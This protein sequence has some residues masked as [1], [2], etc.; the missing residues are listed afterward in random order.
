[1]QFTEAEAVEVKDW[2]VKKLEHISDADSDVLADY[3][4]ALIRSDAPDEEIKKASLENLE[5]FLRENTAQ[6]V[7][8]IFEKFNPKKP[9]PPTA[10]A[11]V[12]SRQQQVQQQQQFLNPTAAS[13]EGNNV[14]QM[15]QQQPY[16]QQQFPTGP[17]NANNRG[18]GFDNNT[19]R[20]RSF[21]EHA[22]GEEQMISRDTNR[23]FKQPRRG[24]MGM[25]MGMGMG[26][27][28][29][30]MGGGGR[31]QHPAQFP[32]AGQQPGGGA[33]FP[34][35]PPAPPGFPPFDPN[36]PMAAMLA[37]QNMFPQMP[38]MPPMPQVPT[39]GGSGGGSGGQQGQG[40]A[41]SSPPAR[42]A[43]RCKDYDTQGF[44][45]LGSTCPYLH[46][47]EHVVAAEEDG[48]EYDPTNARIIDTKA[49]NGANG[50][51]RSSPFR[52]NGR[53]RGGRGR[54]A[55][56]GGGRGD[57][58][59]SQRR[60]RADFSLAGPNDDKSI[61]TI[62]VEQIPEEKF[63]EESIRGFF[64][65][66]GEIVDVTLQAYKHLALVKYDSY[67]S[68]RKAWASPKVIFDNRFVKV[69]WYKPNANAKEGGGGG[70][71]PSGAGAE[72]RPEEPAFDKE[73]FEKQQADAQRAYEEKVKKRKEAEEAREK[74]EKQKEELF[75]K[76]Q[77]ERAKLMERLGGKDASNG[78]TP[79]REGSQENGNG[80]GATPATAQVDDNASEQTKALRAQLAAL[81][82]E[83]KSLGIDP[84]QQQNGDWSSSSYRG[85][86]RGRGGFRARG[87]F[88]PRG[89]GGGYDPSYRGGA[90]YRGRGGPPRGG[91]AGGR[92][93]VLRL[94][95]RP[96]RVAISG[97]Q[98]DAAR[99]EALR[100]FLVGV[101]GFD[102]IEQNPSRPDSQIVSF[103]DRYMAEQ[104]MYGPS[105]IPEVG[106]VEFSWVAGPAPPTAGSSSGAAGATPGQNGGD[107]GDTMMGGAGAG[108]SDPLAA[109]RKDG[110]GNGNGGGGGH[111]VD[112]DVAEVDDGWGI[113]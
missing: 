94:D 100:Q 41:G 33:G 77:E 96:K 86:G 71:R 50:G 92:G 52:G 65:E 83:A 101:G 24:G 27:G 53:E 75:K 106:K 57:F 26:R 59:S 10:P 6:F 69:Y 88:A 111:E 5:D 85:R 109:M 104:L 42:I 108:E 84:E 45:V 14:P 55:R 28:D 21:N 31:P 2:V 12:A 54:G 97:V 112:Y 91:G 13:F 19:S 90:G 107:D 62:V 44:C 79:A 46:G 63:N 37:I 30:R 39:P 3:V 18:G 60:N 38:G 113:E 98:F 16:G 74:L 95:N 70:G 35:M 25:G 102:S 7:D 76:Q 47:V 87:G 49:T 61:T 89:R 36:D 99:D 56:G 67:A 4:L 73:E 68:A 64:S 32:Q 80:R 72:S 58:N 11:A 81:E 34:G 43:Q 40:R 103:K 51:Q 110:N 48:G 22:G 105:D 8:E 78:S 15:Q 17:A 9:E 82:A 66:F 23:Q 20:K 1:M 29:H 93:G